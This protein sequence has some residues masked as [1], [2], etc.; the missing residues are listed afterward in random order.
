MLFAERFREPIRSGDVTVTFRR[1]KRRQVV[2]GRRYRTV[3]GIVEVGAVE[4]VVPADSGDADAVAAGFT[5]A[6]E[7]DP[8]ESLAR[9]APSIEEIDEIDRL[10]RA[11]LHGARARSAAVRLAAERTQDL[12]LR[13]GVDATLVFADKQALVRWT[14]AGQRLATL[15]DEEV[16]RVEGPAEP[17]KPT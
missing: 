4:V 16:C 15:L 11:S 10:D 7:P 8:R 14:V 6:D 1:W 9:S 2:T 3:A 12:E 5:S 13:I 17:A